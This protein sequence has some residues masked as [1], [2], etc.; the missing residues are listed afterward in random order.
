MKINKFMKESY[1]KLL[2]SYNKIYNNK[3]SRLIFYVIIIFIFTFIFVNYIVK[4]DIYSSIDTKKKII[5][6]GQTCDLE[7]N[8]VSINY[9]KGFEIAFD[10]INRNGGING[11]QLRIILYND[12]YEPKLAA[13]NAKL[14]VDYFNV[15]ALIGPFG[16]P[17][18]VAILDDAISGR[19]IPVLFPFTAAT[20]YREIFNKN[21]LLMNGT[22]YNE[23]NVTIKNMIQNNIKNIGIIYQNDIYGKSFYNSFNNYILKNNI[24]INILSTGKYERNTVDLDNCFKDLFQIKDSNDYNDYKDSPVIHDLQGIILFCAEEQV[25]YILGKLKKIKPSLFI[26]YNFFVG[27]AKKN[28]QDLDYYNKNNIYQTLLSPNI[29]IKYPELYNLYIQE[30]DYYNNKKQNKKKIN[31]DSQGSYIGFYCGLLVGE[32]LKNFKNI[33]DLNRESFI[34]MF[35]KKKYFDILGLKV[36]PFIEGVS[37]TGLNYVSL[38]TLKGDKMVLIEEKN[39]N[40]NQ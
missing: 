17:T 10:Y 19:N 27:N 28:F 29:K 1:S 23:F 25:S 2:T 30:V 26:Y 40:S 14:L 20:S 9:S 12:R 5:Y 15:L 7:N 11:Y 6:F 3:T 39:L 24:N 13:D 36:G 31:K 35:Y 4:R 18:T 32:V 38:S 34:D 16:T 33:N 21:L 37:N 8:Q 22:F